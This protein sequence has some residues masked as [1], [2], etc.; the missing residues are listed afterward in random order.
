MLNAA[1]DNAVIPPLRY[2]F[3]AFHGTQRAYAAALAEFAMK[4]LQ[5]QARRA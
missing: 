2:M 1:G 5:G 4:E 3:G